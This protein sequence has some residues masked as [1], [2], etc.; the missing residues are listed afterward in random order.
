MYPKHYGNS[1]LDF[2][3]SCWICSEPQRT[4]YKT[5]PTLH[6]KL[7]KIGTKSPYQGQVWLTRVPGSIPLIHVW[8]TSPYH[9]SL[10]F[11]SDFCALSIITHLQAYSTHFPLQP[12]R[13]HE[14]NSL[15]IHTYCETSYRTLIQ[16]D[17]FIVNCQNFSIWGPSS[18]VLYPKLILI[19]SRWSFGTTFMN[20]VCSRS[21]CSGFFLWRTSDLTSWS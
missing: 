15:P 9:W 20:I 4:S 19:K 3:P 7:N 13:I 12:I 18:S 10:C 6:H 21:D 1:K 14:L 11:D 5:G 8:T 17:C 16:A 2:D